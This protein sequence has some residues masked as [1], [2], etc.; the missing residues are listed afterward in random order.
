[1]KISSK[2]TVAVLLV[3]AG[4]VA[5]CGGGTVD[6]M[7]GPDKAEGAS[8]SDLVGSYE[9]YNDL[10][11]RML[12][13]LKADMT[14]TQQI[15]DVNDQPMGQGKGTWQ[16]DGADVTFNGWKSVM[17]PGAKPTFFTY[18]IPK[19]G[20]YGIYGGEGDPKTVKWFGFIRKK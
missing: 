12:V 10:G 11:D 19:D 1:M 20:G 7:K 17:T 18:K 2:L 4:A 6:E 14:F 9:Y 16:L 13:E 15:F 3:V 8:V 5:G